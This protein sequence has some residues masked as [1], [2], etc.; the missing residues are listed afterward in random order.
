MIKINKKIKY[1]QYLRMEGVEILTFVILYTGI[2]RYARTNQL[3]GRNR[4][5]GLFFIVV[6]R[7]N[8]PPLE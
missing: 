3:H 5:Q 2:N 1:N 7:R 4:L 6:S 8:K